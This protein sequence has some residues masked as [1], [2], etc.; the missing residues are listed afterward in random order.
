MHIYKYIYI[1]YAG[2]GQRGDF[3]FYKQHVVI[4]PTCSCILPTELKMMR[5]VHCLRYVQGKNDLFR[6]VCASGSRCMSCQYVV[7]VV[8]NT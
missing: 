5:N 3:S 6:D 4:Y 8:V 1:L 7:A 2:I